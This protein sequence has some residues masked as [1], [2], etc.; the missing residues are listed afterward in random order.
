MVVQQPDL[1][2][3][4]GVSALMGLFVLALGL[5]ELVVTYRLFAI[6]PTPIADLPNVSGPV[7]VTGVAWIHERTLRAPLTR[8]SCL[9]YEWAIE[10]E[11]T[12]PE[13]E[14]FWETV[15]WGRRSVPFVVE[16]DT[17]S[18]LV[19][20]RNADVRLEGKRNVRPG[21]SG[22]SIG[23]FDLSFDGS[24]R[25]MET[26]LDPDEPVYVYGTVT[27]APGESREAGQVNA[28]IESGEP[29]IIADGTEFE[30]SLRVFGRAAFFIAFA[31]FWLGIIVFILLFGEPSL[32]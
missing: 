29:F 20:P 24:K 30:A 2:V 15:K 19:D 17:G 12:D 3:F 1:V 9:A 27:Y 14:T 4:L 23:P 22:L 11:R 10:E 31:L 13:G 32:T 16:D 7:E 18:V 5:R 8:R 25:Y 21:V 6:E 26:R 28:R